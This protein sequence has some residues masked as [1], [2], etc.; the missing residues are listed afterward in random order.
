MIEKLGI[1][2]DGV[3]YVNL[4]PLAKTWRRKE[5]ASE[6]ERVMKKRQ[7]MREQGK[8]VG[9][10]GNTLVDFMKLMK[11]RVP[12]IHAAGRSTKR[13]RDVLGQLERRDSYAKLTPTCKAKWTKLIEHNRL[14][15]RF[16]H[17]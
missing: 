6:H 8:R 7:K 5:H 9:S 2:L 17:T 3:A 12:T 1:S 11:V 10:Y 16:A 14:D 15:C 13:L 4:L